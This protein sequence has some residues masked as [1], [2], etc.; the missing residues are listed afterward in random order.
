MSHHDARYRS[1]EISPGDAM[2]RDDEGAGKAE[3]SH[4][5]RPEEAAWVT[6]KMGESEGMPSRNGKRK[7]D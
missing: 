4:E 3:V 6:G 2:G 5:G 7:R 1:E